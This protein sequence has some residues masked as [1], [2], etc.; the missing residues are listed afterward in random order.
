LRQLTGGRFP[1]LRFD[2][3]EEFPAALEEWCAVSGVGSAAVACGIGM[4]EETDLGVFD[5]AS[6]THRIFHEPAEVLSLQGN[7]SMRDGKPF[8]HVHA[9]I[10]MHDFSAS[11][12]HL[13]SGR[14]AVTLEVML[15]LLEG[16]LVRHPSEG[17]FR[18]LDAAK[19]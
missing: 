4:L 6:Y 13:F 1:L 10:G 19:P 17:S 7:V 5:G 16:G 8:A 2:R 15:C 18:P 14:V 12:G 9:S 11:G 3:G